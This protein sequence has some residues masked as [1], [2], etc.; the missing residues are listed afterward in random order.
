M[1]KLAKIIRNRVGFTLVELMLVM[2]LMLIFIGFVFS[3]FYLVNS[4]HANVVVINDAKD[5]AS[6]NMDAISKLVINADKVIISGTA[7]PSAGQTSVYFTNSVLFY[8]NTSGATQAFT[9]NQ[10]TVA[11]GSD[12]WQI[13]STFT[14]KGTLLTVQLNVYDNATS[15]KQLYY[16]LTRDIYLPNIVK[17]DQITG[18]SGTVV[19]YENF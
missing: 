5:F 3:T 6:L 4:S 11:G 8:S 14:K 2:A 16:T 12:K 19:T 18:S 15:P 17:A 9:Y 1:R 13:L 7:V 10:Y